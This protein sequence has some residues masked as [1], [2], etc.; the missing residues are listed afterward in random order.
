MATRKRN[1]L[2][3]GILALLF[4]GFGLYRFFIHY[5]G[6]EVLESWKLVVAGASLVYG[7]FLAYTTLTQKN[8]SDNE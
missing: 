4:I 1:P 3:G 6:Q 8:I 5:N 7:L 2:M